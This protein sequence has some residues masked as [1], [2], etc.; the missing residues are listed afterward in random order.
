VTGHR[1]ILSAGGYASR[2]FDRKKVRSKGDV[3]I[4][5]RP[6]VSASATDEYIVGNFAMS[7]RIADYGSNSGHKARELRATVP[8]P[9]SGLLR[10]LFVR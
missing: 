5:E 8:G 6:I 3:E 4:R 9:N 2:A 10:A 7:Q 1:A